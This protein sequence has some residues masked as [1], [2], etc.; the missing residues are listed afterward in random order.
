MKIKPLQETGEI[1]LSRVVVPGI[2]CRSRR[3]S[4]R[5]HC[6]KLYV[7]YKDYIKNVAS[8][9]IYATWPQDTIRANV[10]A[11][12]VIYTKPRLY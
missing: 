3:L 7:K 11:I 5:Q 10:L 4:A 12:Y 6:K 2:H 1:V 9:E 8:S